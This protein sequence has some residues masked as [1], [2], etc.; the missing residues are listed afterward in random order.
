MPCRHSANTG[1][2]KVG[3]TTPSAR[4]RCVRSERALTLG[5]YPNAAAAACTRSRSSGRTVS[6]ALKARE[7]VAGETPAWLETSRIVVDCKEG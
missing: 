6:G 1:F 4:V 2:D 7:T 5:R 3:S